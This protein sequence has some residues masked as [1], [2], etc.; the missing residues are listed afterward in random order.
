MQE[1]KLR[2]STT[3]KKIFGVCGG[4][5][6]YFNV[7]PSFVRVL[8]LSALFALSAGFWIYLIFALIMPQ[9]ESLEVEI[10]EVKKVYRAKKGAVLFGVCG[11]LSKY[12]NT[13]I[14]TIRL[15]L[16]LL[17]LF[18]GYGLLFYISAGIILPI[19]PNE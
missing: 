17:F 19:D 10:Q 3:D 11:G 16:V 2:R 1:I 14:V 18:A 12:F 5:G 13:D 15:I 9:E 6:K 4:I 7:D 8:F